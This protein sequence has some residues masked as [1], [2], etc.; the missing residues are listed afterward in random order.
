MSRRIVAA[1]A[2]AATLLI[3]PSAYAASTE[4]YDRSAFD[5]TPEVI[6]SGWTLSAATSGELGGWLDMS[7][8][9]ADGSVPPAG[10]CE[11]ANVDAVLTVAPG[12]T[13]TVHTTA[14]LC[15]HFIDG[16]PSLFGSFG[17]KQVTYH[18]AHKKARLVGDGF[19]SFGRSAIGALGSV[20][21]TVRR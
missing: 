14:E 6:A 3:T 1:G 19:V 15:G 9:A 20:T 21:L 11:P 7:V 5:G 10:Q 8:Q 2:A 4:T 12:E 16:S 17:A 18:G 13:F